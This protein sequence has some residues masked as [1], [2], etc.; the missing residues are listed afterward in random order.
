MLNEL[1]YRIDDVNFMVSLNCPGRCVYCNLG[2]VDEAEIT[3][4]E[5][6]PELCERFLS[7]R[8]LK[9]VDYFDLTG[10]ESQLSSKYADVVRMII[11]SHPGAFVHT[12]ISGWYTN[13]HV[14]VTEECLEFA[15][16]KRFRI[17][18]SMDGRPEVYEKV[19]L[20][21]NGWNKA[22]ETARALRDRGVLVRFVFIMHR[23]NYQDIEWIADFAASQE[24]DFVIGY[25]HK[26]NLL[27]NTKTREPGFT[28]QQIDEIESALDR[29][30]YMASDRK[31]HWLWAKS[32]YTDDIPFFDC[33]MGKQTIVIDPYGNVFPCNDLKPDLNMG[34]LREFDGDLDK[35]LLS[36]QALSV[37]ENVGERK[38][39][40]CGMLCAHKVVFPWGSHPDM[41][42][43][44]SS[45]APSRER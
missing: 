1:S 9:D 39:Q 3:R 23:T 43:D 12:N 24:V 28:P 15:D 29:I 41:A 18:V 37:L 21:Y 40:P 45:G 25:S 14:E 13:R 10:G 2:E 44:I 6:E 7:S 26:A 16:P 4:G 33:H 36:K 34:S 22:V 11:E 32:V 27:R 31:N 35:L 19:R 8:I 30:G 5:I 38:C 42:R 17:D 20:V